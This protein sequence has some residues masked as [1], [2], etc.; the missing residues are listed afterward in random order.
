MANHF[1]SANYNAHNAVDDVDILQQ[2]CAVDRSFD[3]TSSYFSCQYALS[4]YCYSLNV[5][6]NIHSLYPLLDNKI[7][8]KNIARKIA[9]SGLSMDNLILAFDRSG[10]DGI[11][12]VFSE[13]INKS[14]RVTRSTKIIDS[15]SKYISEKMVTESS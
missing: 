14:V 8:S 15:V 4:V 6:K 13:E 5:S 2:L 9:G 11:R 10:A 12:N 3:M 7:I 1:L